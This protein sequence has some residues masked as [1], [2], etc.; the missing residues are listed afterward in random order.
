MTTRLPATRIGRSY[1]DFI[2]EEEARDPKFAALRAELAPAF[3]IANAVVTARARLQM[4]QAQ[5]ASRMATTNTAVSRLESGRQVPTLETLQKLSDILGLT[6]MIGPT[7][8]RVTP[9][10]GEES[11]AT[12][13]ASSL[14][15]L[16]VAPDPQNSDWTVRHDGGVLQ[17]ERTQANAVKYARNALEGNGGQ[18][19]IR[20][21]NG[22]L[23]EVVEVQPAAAA[24]AS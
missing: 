13:I 19:E 10:N 21:R 6:F 23:R 4:S 20:R 14:P 22:L 2:A 16:V 24:A 15:R 17:R 8:V 12:E 11:G 5:L 9:T 7:A 18:L 3:A 1:D